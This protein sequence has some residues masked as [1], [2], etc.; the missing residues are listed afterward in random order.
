MI[1]T[2]S[3]LESVSQSSPNPRLITELVRFHSQFLAKLLKLVRRGGLEPP[4]CYSLAPQASASA[5]SATSAGIR[6]VCCDYFFAG[7][8]RGTAGAE[9]C[10]GRRFRSG[11]EL[12]PALRVATIDNDIDVT[13]NKIADIVVAFESKVADPLGPKAVWE[14]IPPNAPA[15]SA[16]LPL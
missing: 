5:N 11:N 8:G 7:A 15:R 12:V 13:M 9:F 1:V 6:R 14:P 3:C 10:T 2:T 16:A 4:R